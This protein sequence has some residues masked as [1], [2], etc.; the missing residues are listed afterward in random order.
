[1]SLLGLKAG[2]TLRLLTWT[3]PAAMVWARAS[4]QIE[5]L[6]A[7]RLRRPRYSRDHKYVSEP[8]PVLCHRARRTPVCLL[9][10]PDG[11]C[12][13][14]Q[15][16]SNSL[17]LFGCVATFPRIVMAIYRENKID[18][19]SPRFQMKRNSLGK[20][21]QSA[22]VQRTPPCPLARDQAK[23]PLARDAY[24]QA[25]QQSDY[26]RQIAILGFRL[27]IPDYR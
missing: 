7:G 20:V 1:M 21:A 16:N 23:K 22:I 10:N 13:A 14:K 15:R 12:G 6:Q 18:L 5:Q 17:K 11:L 26:A 9:P 8:T 19:G 2:G 24:D 3:G 25:Q 27:A 4:L